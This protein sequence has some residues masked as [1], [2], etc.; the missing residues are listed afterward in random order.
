MVYIFASYRIME[1]IGSGNFGDV[2]K[3]VWEMPGES[4][5]VA[6]KTMKHGTN[7][8]DQ[9]MFLQEAAVNGQFR[10]PNVVKLYGVVTVGEPV[11]GDMIVACSTTP[12]YLF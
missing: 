6:V 12:T 1:E 10:H 4:R 8:T 3:G 5:L 9:V 7:S 11:S 2:H